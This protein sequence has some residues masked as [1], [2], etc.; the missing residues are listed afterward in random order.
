M[1]TEREKVRKIFE[2]GGQPLTAFVSENMAAAHPGIDEFFDVRPQEDFEE[3]P[4]EKKL[5]N[6]DVR[7]T[8][9]YATALNREPQDGFYEN[10]KS[11]LETYGSSTTCGS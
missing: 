11:E 9:F 3:E 6:Q 1:A 7:Q 10:V 2:E 4:T 5:L 8:A